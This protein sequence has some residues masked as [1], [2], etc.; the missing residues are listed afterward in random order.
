MQKADIVIIGAGA[1][2]IALARELSKYE[3]RVMVVD[4][5]EDVGGDASKSCSSCISTES[6]VT[7]FTLESEICQKSRPL[8]DK[9]C[10]DLEVPLHYC[11]SITPAIGRQQLEK[12]PAMLKKAFDNGVYDVEFLRPEEILEMEPH[13]NPELLGGL[14]SPRD[15]QVNQFLL[16][17]AQAENAAENG[18]D[19]WLNCRVEDIGRA[20][21]GSVAAVLTSRGEIQTSWVINAAGLY[22]DQIARLV[23]ECDF[24]V[25]PRKGQF[26]LLDKNTPVKVSHII[27]SI[28][29]PQ[30]R[31][32]LIIPT[33][34]GNILV[35][36]TAEDLEDKNDKKTTREGL[37]EVA[38]EAKILV[39]DLRLEDTITQ[40]V[41]LR[42]AREPE[43][44]N[45]VV[46]TK[47]PGYV[48]ISGIRSSGLTGSLGLAKYTVEQMRQAGLSLKRRAGFIPRRRGIVNFSSA[49]DEEREKLIALDPRYGRVICRCE[50]ITEAEIVQAI[51]R[52][53]GA[54]SLDAIKRRVRAG[55]GRC[56]GGFCGPQVMEILSRELGLPA[57]QISKRGG[58]S[59]M[60]KA[61]AR[62]EL[63]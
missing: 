50:T 42:P 27:L 18:V 17:S 13:L 39:P 54:R 25:H 10:A 51:H 21:D 1:V 7:P 5:N 45:I 24:T 9:L 41:G 53:L 55:S 49:S 29:L 12:V 38:R 60:I 33:V 4:K 61:L 52:P 32:K 19:F 47:A 58:Q 63:P 16:V 15:T 20:T 11:G 14:Y 46:S 8:Y 28:P 6:T 40:F 57:D 48:G 59:F 35:G 2:G 44:Y 3:L 56:Q 36:P 37:E 43:G 22:C 34:D 30:T 31:G 62:P 26:Y 23:G